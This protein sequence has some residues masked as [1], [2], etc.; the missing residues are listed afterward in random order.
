VTG[1][2]SGIG[3]G[4]AEALVAAGATTIIADIEAE[5]AQ[6]VAAEIGATGLACDVS[7]RDSVAA[8]R[9]EVEDR[10]GA[11]AVL[12]NN[13][14]VGSV[15]NLDQM[16]AEDW[17]WMLGINLYGVIHGVAEFRD[18][19]QGE[20]HGAVIVNTASM[21]ALSPTVGMGVYGVAKAG[22]LALT[23]VLAQELQQAGSA[24]RAHVI[25]P[26]PVHTQIGRS[27]RSRDGGATGLR[28]VELD[29]LPTPVDH[30]REPKEIG[31]LVVDRIIN[32]GDLL[33]VTHPEQI[34]RVEARQR[35]ISAAFEE[36]ARR[37][38]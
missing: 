23:E 16:T 3:R 31:E 37:E 2:A 34:D 1:G 9:R 25:T 30:V 5:K 17:E 7:D 20:E 35:R 13:A 32:G 38:G 6:R 8:L 12:V 21:A 36:A 18:L 10:F 26:G 19:L 15:G 14:G 29:E 27:Q 4:I 28:D 24:L 33:I 11:L 22:V